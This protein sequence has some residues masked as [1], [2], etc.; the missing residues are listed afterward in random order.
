MEIRLVTLVLGDSSRPRTK[1]STYN[2]HLNT[3]ELVGWIGEMDKYF[4]HEEFDEEKRV[5]FAVT[6][7]RGHATLFW[8]GV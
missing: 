8:D 5:T 7:L 1:V 2:G 4:E 6:K 3:E